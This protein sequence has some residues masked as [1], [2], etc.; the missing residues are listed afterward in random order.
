[1]RYMV[2]IA[3]NAKDEQAQADMTAQI[4][5]EQ[6]HIR[7]WI[8]QGVA[9]AL[10]VAVGGGHAWLILHGDSI[11]HVQNLLMTLPLYPYINTEIQQLSGSMP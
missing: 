2:T 4:P 5:A 9:E 3:G 10:H 8:A 6:A 11:E 1:M 7:E